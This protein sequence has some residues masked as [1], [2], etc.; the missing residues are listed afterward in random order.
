MTSLR[1]A[2]VRRGAAASGAAAL[3]AAC[4]LPGGAADA[5]TSL[6]VKLSDFKV[7]PSKR[8]VGH[9]KVTFRVKNSASMEHELV[10]IKTSKKASQLASGGKASEKGSVGEVEL[11]GHRSKSLTLNLKKGHYALLCNIGGHYMAGMHADLTVR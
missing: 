4:L 11:A 8:S 3:L 9:G 5:A 2:N 7:T 6:N 10:V 1:N